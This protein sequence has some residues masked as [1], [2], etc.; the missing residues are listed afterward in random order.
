MLIFRENHFYHRQS[1]KTAGK[2]FISF[3]PGRNSFSCMR[4]L[5]QIM[6]IFSVNLRNLREKSLFL[7]CLAEIHFH[8]CETYYR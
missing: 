6:N 8:E 4:K 1:A 7:S 2:I 5:L 3:L